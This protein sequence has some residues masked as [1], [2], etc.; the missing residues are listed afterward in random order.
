MKKKWLSGALVASLLATCMPFGG[1]EAA[2]LEALPA[3]PG[4]EGGGKYVTGGRAQPVYEVTT[5]ADYGI[6]ETPIPGSFRDAVSQS[7]RTI[8]FRV[9]GTIHLKESL[10]ITGSNLTIAGQTAPGDGITI[11]DYTTSVEA[12]NII[13][14]YMRFRLGDRVASEDDAFGS[15]YHKDLIIDHSS[16]SWSVD[17]VVSLYDNENTTVQWSISAESMLMTTHQK[18]RHGYGGIWGGKNASFLHN[19]I[20]HST[21]RNPRLPTV[22]KLVDLTEMSNNVI[23]NWGFASTYGGGA[24]DYR[25]NITNNYYKNGPNTYTSVKNQ[26]FGE[27]SPETRLFIDGNIMDGNPKVTEDNWKGVQKYSNISRLAEPA[28]MPNPYTALSAEEAYAN[29]MA[30][31]GATLP[32]RDAYDARVINDV[33]NRTGQHINSPIEIGGYPDYTETASNVIDMDHD[34]MDDSWEIANGLDP[35]DSEDGK[36]TTLSAEGYTNLEVYLNDLIVLGKAGNEHTDN[37]VTAINYPVNNQ[38][39]ESGNN[40]NVTASAS[41][42]DG[43]AKVEF[44]VNGVKQAEATTAPYSFDW[45]NVQDGTYYLVVQAV[46]NKGLKTQSDNVAIHVNTSGSVLPWTSVDVGRPGIAGVTTLH[47]DSGKITLKSAGLIGATSESETAVDNFQFA[48]QTLTGNGEIIARI[49][50]V[51][52]TDDYAK[53]GVMIRDNLNDNSKMTMLAIPY[54]KYGK[55]GVMITRS[56]TGAKVVKTEPDSFINTPYWV[57]LVRL[58]NEVTGLVSPDKVTW[59]KVGTVKLDLNDTV[60]FGL[61]AD[62]AKVD[63]EVN[64]YN[65][66]VF[67]EVELKPLSD[68]FP[69]APR[70]LTATAGE[71]K[72]KLNWE[73]VASAKS[74]SVKR[75]EVSGGPYKTINTEIKDS[76]YTDSGLSSGKTYYYVVSAV[77]ELGE[78]FDSDEASATAE[79]EAGNVYYVDEDF[80][81]VAVGVTP[82]YYDVTPNPQTEIQKVIVSPTPSDS[83]G[84]TSDQV[85][86]V[87][88][89]A[90]GSVQFI[91]KFAPITGALV[92][93]TDFMFATESGTSV[94]LQAQSTD[95]SKTAFSIESRKPTLPEATGK[96]TL[97]MSRGSSQYH[98]LMSSYSLKQW[99]NL[100]LKVDVNNDKVDVYIDDQPAGSF[101]FTTTNFASYGIGRILSKT[102]GGGSGNYYLDNLKIYVE[103][104]ET[105]L[106]LTG[107]PGNQAAQLSWPALEGATSYNVKRSLKSGGPYETIANAITETSYIDNEVTNETTYYYVISATAPT[108]ESGNSNEISITPSALAV[109]LPAPESFAAVSRNAQLD[110]SWKAVENAASYSIKKW[111]ETSGSY[112]LV[113]K[114]ITG[115]TYRVGGLANGQTY[116]YVVAAT[117]VAGEGK[118]SAPVEA[119]PQSPLGTPVVSTEAGDSVMKLSWPAIEEASQYIVKRA[120]SANGPYEV[121]GSDLSDTSFTDAGLV[122]GTPYYYKVKAIS[123]TRSS[124]D[125]AATPA[126]PYKNSG[127]P[128]APQGVSVEPG[129]TDIHLTWNVADGASSY[130]ILRSE[131]GGSYA[132]VADGI[133]ATDY[134]DK[135]LSNGTAYQYAVIAIGDKGASLPSE[136]VK[137]IPAPVIIVAQNGTGDYK[138]INDAIQAA[139]D[140]SALTTIIKV[141]NGTYKEK[142]LVPSSKMNISIIG[143]SREGTVLINGDSAKTT[144]SD[145]KEMGTSGS[146]TLKVAATDFTLENMTVENSAGRD[147]GQAVALYAEGDRGVY[148]N[149]KLLGYQDTLFAD[150]GR[151][152][153]VDSHIEGTVD[154]IFGNS[155]AVFENNVIQSAGAGYVTAPSTATGKPGYVFINN[156]LTASE[157]VA[158]GTVDLGR[159][160]REYGSSTFINTEMGA[161]IRATGWHEWY[162]GRSKTARFS[163]FLSYGEGAN[164]ASRYSWSKQITAEEAAAYTIEAVLGG[165]DGWNPQQSKILVGQEQIPAVH[166][167]SI[168][169]TGKDGISSIESKGGALQLQASVLPENA[170][171][172]KVIWTVTEADGITSTDKAVINEKGLL[173]ARKNGSVQVTARA[174]DGS[175]VSGSLEIN[176][177]GQDEIARNLPAAT[178]NG[179]VTVVAGQDFTYRVGL[180]NVTTSVYKEVYAVDFTMAYDVSGVE[181][182]SA[183]TLPDGF[184]ITHINEDS[185]GLITVSVAGTEAG[186]IL[187]DDA[188][189][190]EIIFKAKKTNREIAVPLGFISFRGSNTDV[191]FDILHEAQSVVHVIPISVMEIKVSSKDN[192]SEIKSG[193]TLQMAAVILPD[194][195]SDPAVTWSVV[196]EDGSAT[197]RATITDTGLLTAIAA[198]KV[199]VRATAKDDSG[200]VGTMSIEIKA[201]SQVSESGGTSSS[202]TVKPVK[203]PEPTVNAD[204]VTLSV[205]AD[206]N[207]KAIAEVS[208]TIL[209]QAIG[210]MQNGVLRI[211]VKPSSASSVVELTLPARELAGAGAKAIQLLEIDMGLSTFRIN[212][213]LLLAMAGSDAASVKLVVGKV[214]AN[215]LSLQTDVGDIYEF[216]FFVDGKQFDSFGRGLKVERDYKPKTTS[217]VEQIVAYQIREDGTVEVVR[218]SQFNPTTGKI[219]FRPDN[220]SRFAV[221]YAENS[222]KDIAGLGWAQNSIQ[223]L[224]ARD[225]LN[226]T[227]DHNFGPQ[228]N[229]TRAQ[230]LKMLMLAL[231]LEEGNA[232]STFKDVSLDAWYYS[233]VAAA[234]QLGI[235]QGRSDGTFGANETISREEMALMAYRAAQL[236]KLT[237]VEVDQPVNF[238]DA[239]DVS[240]Y[241]REAV[242]FMSGAKIIQGVGKDNFAPKANT[243]R[244][245]AAVIVYRLFQ[246]NP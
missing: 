81:Q 176:I 205:T 178:L 210:S 187:T 3:F 68:Q 27:V 224:A 174:L 94:F 209:Q 125:S 52:G 156:R 80:E 235:I 41:D 135:G 75:S 130:Q 221:G 70:G 237:V 36:K 151:A 216:K 40:V 72:V 226:G 148:R 51:T 149:V 83:K 146:Y 186:N 112:E 64:R 207:G 47:P 74:Y 88:D 175:G 30:D 123:G 15:R 214:D 157:G 19:L 58:G 196:N 181:F 234:Q 223:A 29:V 111:N 55:K 185:P 71:E 53:A 189:F 134:T 54:V 195:A 171:N 6:K 1:V 61:A 69:A 164:A 166:V 143:E 8:V 115:T 200:V 63:N 172:P 144:G 101:L 20:A 167:S 2:S 98:Q 84:N 138:T 188:E 45:N 105:P 13:M 48:Y 119:T 82:E 161:H 24:E 154:F 44:I 241:A 150:K 147:A 127:Q 35:T 192:V 197:E 160:W 91:R 90:N 42:S 246:L 173:T 118:E 184:S 85:L 25:Y 203:Q 66:S 220:S 206:V 213:D 60:Y 245:Q 67:S 183:Q 199:T 89:G 198:G 49:D 222:F 116:R 238:N 79:G 122:N 165:S 17:E 39:I 152:Y 34:G 140:N 114:E 133:E 201:E 31:A 233:S 232:A 117:N 168:T 219:I 227:G 182:I 87:F 240:A 65:A 212:A 180:T 104:I 11:A 46:D 57:K 228:L 137:G 229:V 243:T 162:E 217:G 142:V 242:Q 5:L 92:I 208:S 62:A 204:G 231:E 21:S 16:F 163:E 121:L 86:N 7:N 191:D 26:L 33:K 136:V 22:T 99:Y 177:S 230:F 194:H 132:V 56:T 14:R 120:S 159:P 169:V 107:L 131:S 32:R 78:S 244:A 113:A 97:T 218:N 96:Y 100:K 12:D 128:Q 215:T 193:Q 139:P 103:P 95:G 4:A 76:L 38:I 50:S 18:G 10:K 102:P 77:N 155:A 190:L 141:K 158:A 108:G 28:K 170:T 145:G 9:G 211:T 73:D 236:A 153:F 239:A 37:P 179:P 106:G 124:L 225:I 43:I 59:S 93:D 126:V 109:K 129:N 202:T 23:Y 110:L